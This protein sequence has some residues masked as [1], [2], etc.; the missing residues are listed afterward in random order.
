[1]KYRIKG[2][3]YLKYSDD[4][5]DAIRK[6]RTIAQKTGRWGKVEDNSKLTGLTKAELYTC[7]SHPVRGFQEKYHYEE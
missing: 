4:I 3:W 1:M 5:L 2:Y 6:A 7:Y